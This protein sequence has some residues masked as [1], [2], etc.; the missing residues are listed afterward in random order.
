MR[1]LHREIG[2]LRE[3]NHNQNIEIA[4]LKNIMEPKNDALIIPANQQLPKIS[5]DQHNKAM[6]NGTVMV[7]DDNSPGKL[8]KGTRNKRPVRLLPPHVYMGDRRNETE[9]RRFYGPPTNCSDLKLLGYTLNGYYQVK[10]ADHSSNND[11]TKLETI[12]CAFKQP[13]GT[14]NLSLVERRI[15]HLQLIPHN[16][17]SV[18]TN[19]KLGLSNVGNH[20][21]EKFVRGV[22]FYASRKIK[23]WRNRKPSKSYV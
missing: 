1:F 16:H 17:K 6:A 19:E 23:K 3:E 13:E 7:D 18:L 14:F 20:P 10:Q 5:D 11:N 21:L 8:T 9:I 15:G 2:F 4:N 22:Y 12:Y